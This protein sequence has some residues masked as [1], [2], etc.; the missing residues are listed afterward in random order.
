MDDNGTETFA[1][2]PDSG[3]SIGRFPD[4][5]DSNDNG[6]DFQSSMTPSP[7]SENI[8]NSGSENGNDGVAPESG[9]GREPSGGEEPSKCSYVKGIPDMT[10]FTII[11]LMFRRRS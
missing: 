1:L 2:F 9:C 5:E 3:K 7:G 6:V 11:F 4:G 8:A 10:W